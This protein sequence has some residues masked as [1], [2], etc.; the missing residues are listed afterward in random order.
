[1]T[2]V[3]EGARHRGDILGRGDLAG[4]D[5][6]ALG[7]F[8]ACKC[9]SWA[10]SHASILSLRHIFERGT[11]AVLCFEESYCPHSATT[12]TDVV[13][14]VSVLSELPGCHS[15]HASSGYPP[16]PS[17]N[18]FS[19]EHDS[20][21]QGDSTLDSSTVRISRY[22]QVPVFCPFF[23]TTAVTRSRSASTKQNTPVAT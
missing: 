10:A 21:V 3:E 8:L 9:E 16:S 18:H 1:M 2:W 15:K 13:I 4:R 23:H 11:P 7:V 6:W 17:P 19:L 12:H 22:F 5:V 14:P 20:C